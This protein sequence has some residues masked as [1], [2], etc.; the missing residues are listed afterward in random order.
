MRRFQGTKDL[1]TKQI[2]RANLQVLNKRIVVLDNS[3]VSQ[4]NILRSCSTEKQ[5]LSC[6]RG[7]LQPDSFQG[8][9]SAFLV[10]RQKYCTRVTSALVPNRKINLQT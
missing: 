5:R 10:R 7:V 4:F 9:Q 1:H 6:L 3:I 8:D 2:E